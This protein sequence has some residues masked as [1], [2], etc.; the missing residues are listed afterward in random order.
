MIDKHVFDTLGKKLERI[1]K[2]EPDALVIRM[3][4]CS[5]M[6][7][8]SQRTGEMGDEERGLFKAR[9]RPEDVRSFLDTHKPEGYRLMDT[10]R[11][12]GNQWYFSLVHSTEFQ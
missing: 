8:I 5:K 2:A 7:T 10:E 12:D 3:T 9:V 11:M 4:P 1:A 6:Y